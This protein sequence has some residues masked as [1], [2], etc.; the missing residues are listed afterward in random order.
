MLWEGEGVGADWILLRVRNVVAGKVSWVTDRV[1]TTSTFVLVC[2]P[3]TCILKC[4]EGV[5]RLQNFP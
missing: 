5:N 2:F 3:P 4:R 1:R